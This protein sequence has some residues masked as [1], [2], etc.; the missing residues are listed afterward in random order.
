MK[1]IR[2]GNSGDLFI[3]WYV[4]SSQKGGTIGDA[5]GPLGMHLQSSHVFESSSFLV[6]LS[7]NLGII[8]RAIKFNGVT[9]WPLKYLCW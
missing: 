8:G 6:Y 3:I 1:A 5:Q 4:L 7:I 2:S 9:L